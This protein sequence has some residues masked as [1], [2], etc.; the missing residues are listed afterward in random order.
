MTTQTI[1]A[2]T[3]DVIRGVPV[4]LATPFIRPWHMRWGA[5]D[6]E[7]AAPMAG[8]ELVPHAQFDS[9]R[10][11]TIA[12][13]PEA[14]WPW[15]VQVGYGKAGFYSY[16][17]F[18]NLARPSADAILSDLQHPVIGDWVAMSGTVNDVTAFRVAGFEPERWMLWSKPGS[19]WAWKLEPTPDGGTRLVTRLK[20]RHDF[21]K[22][23]PTLLSV[24]L[25]EFGDFPMMR[26][27]LLG[28]RV[29]AERLSGRPAA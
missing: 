14:V 4:F 17:L 11:I 16:D 19:T 25:S 29:R 15:I 3:A 2:A 9:T 23:A 27:M 13:P 7:L 1:A 8:D 21:H 5:T 20:M 24:F 10:A 6:E 26:R 28:I 22:V 12:A 18:D